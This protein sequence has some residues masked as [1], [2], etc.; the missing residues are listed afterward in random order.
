MKHA[1]V[2]RWSNAWSIERE[3]K[4]REWWGAG[5][6]AREISEKFACGITRNAVIGKAHR[7]QLSKRKSP[8]IRNPDIDYKTGRI[9]R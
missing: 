9:F 2:I 1:K 8:I 7:M 5:Y 4:L 6:S 3:N